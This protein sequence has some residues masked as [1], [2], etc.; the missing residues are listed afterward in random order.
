MN[1]DKNYFRR[2]VE[3]F[4]ATEGGLAPGQEVV[5]QEQIADSGSDLVQQGNQ[6]QQEVVD[7]NANVVEDQNAQLEDPE[8]LAQDNTVSQDPSAL[9]QPQKL[10]SVYELFEKLLNYAVIFLET[11]ETV[12]KSILDLEAYKILVTYTR[13]TR[14]LIDKIN[15]YMTNIFSQEEYDKVLYTYVL[16]RTELIV[17]IKGIRDILQLNNPKEKYQRPDEKN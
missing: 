2:L 11:L 5:P 12:D 6:E 13:N 7:D 16:F 8:M 1:H 9:L 4:E 17:N 15:N 14:E 3:L 10:L